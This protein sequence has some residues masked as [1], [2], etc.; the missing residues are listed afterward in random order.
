MDIVRK[1]FKIIDSTNTWAKHNVHLFPHDKI[2]LVTADEQTAGRGRF[3]RKWESPANQNL[4]ATFCF[5]IEKHRL[6]IGNIPQVL[7]LSAINALKKL[8]F[9]PQLKWPNDIL[10]NHKKVS[11][12]LCETTPLSDHLGIILGIGI[13]VNM[14]LELLQKIDRPA[15]S[16]L[17]EQGNLLQI[18]EVLNSL[19]NAFIGDLEIFLEEG[20]AH[21]LSQYREGMQQWVGKNIRFHDNRYIWE[22]VF[23]SINHDGSLN[24]L[25]NTGESKNFLTGE[26][27]FD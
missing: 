4:Y 11:G 15:T 18:E 8:G 9:N 6:D 13:N 27:L 16:L 24:M 2:T 22:G 7:A 23:Q 21:F 12:I 14:P 20:F 10:L 3:R 26:I 19:Q 5:F 17:V 25:L 1:H